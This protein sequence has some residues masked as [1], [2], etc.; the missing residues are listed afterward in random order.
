MQAEVTGRTPRRV[1]RALALPLAAL[2]GGPPVLCATPTLNLEG[3]ALSSTRF[4]RPKNSGMSSQYLG[5]CPKRPSVSGVTYMCQHAFS[6]GEKKS[7][8]A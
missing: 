7:K 3:R 1:A 5:R 2:S 4:S 6:L 8:P